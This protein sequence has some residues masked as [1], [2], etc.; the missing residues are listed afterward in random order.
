MLQLKCIKFAVGCLHFLSVIYL[1]T[2]VVNLTICDTVL[3]FPDLL[4]NIYFMGLK[5]HL[6]S[7]SYNM[8]YTSCFL[9]RTQKRRTESWSGSTILVEI[10]IVLLKISDRR[11]LQTNIAF[12]EGNQLFAGDFR[13]NL[14]ETNPDM[15]LFRKRWNSKW[16]F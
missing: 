7:R 13:A 8:G 3:S 5:K 1:S 4:L 14:D 12:S 15:A 11:S 10:L 2:V 16:I 6:L 9:Q